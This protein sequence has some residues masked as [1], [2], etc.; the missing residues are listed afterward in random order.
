MREDEFLV[1]TLD[2]MLYCPAA[3]EEE[4][5]EEEEERSSIGRRR[6]RRRYA[7]LKMDVEGFEMF[8]VKGGKDF[9]STTHSPIPVILHENGY[10]VLFL[11]LLLLLCLTHPPNQNGYLFVFLLPTH[12]L[13]DPRIL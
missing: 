12:P 11:L 3:A 1:T 9:L 10:V 2:S 6:R 4:E 13:A 8:V 7:G 5:E